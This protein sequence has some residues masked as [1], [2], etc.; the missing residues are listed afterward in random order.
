MSNEKI[1]EAF[2]K[3]GA[4]PTMMQTL[5]DYNHEPIIVKKGIQAICALAKDS[6]NRED[7][8]KAG[9]CELMI[10]TVK[11]YLDNDEIISEFVL[12]FLEFCNSEA[13][14]E[15]F[16]DGLKKSFTEEEITIFVEK[17]SSIAEIENEYKV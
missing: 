17:L 7:F 14:K 2:R 12:A 16:S 5:K 10:R 1:Q 6:T 8:V 4:I 15:R 3:S 11:K 13:G 9:A